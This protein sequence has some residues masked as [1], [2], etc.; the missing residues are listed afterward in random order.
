MVPHWLQIPPCVCAY[1]W[2]RGVRAEGYGQRGT[3]RGVRAEGYAPRCVGMARSM[4]VAGR[5]KSGRA[6]AAAAAAAAA[7]AV[8]YVSLSLA[9]LL[10]DV[11]SDVPSDA[12]FFGRPLLFFGR[13]IFFFTWPALLL[14]AVAGCA[15]SQQRC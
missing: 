13:P 14:P 10:V 4:D 12:F 8:T 9:S 3:D 2:R 7:A 6:K 11:P 5:P 1:V 15:P